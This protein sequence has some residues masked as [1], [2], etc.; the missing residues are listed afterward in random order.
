MRNEQI[1]FVKKTFIKKQQRAAYNVAIIGFLAIAGAIFI[2][3]KNVSL[4]TVLIISGI[5]FILVRI[6]VIEA[7]LEYNEERY[8]RELIAKIDH[9]DWLKDFEAKLETYDRDL[10]SGQ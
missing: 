8:Y 9:D 6:R 1:E 5:G 10:K 4:D 7:R 3:N 2:A